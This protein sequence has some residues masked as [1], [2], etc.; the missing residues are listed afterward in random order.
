MHDDRCGVGPDY[1]VPDALWAQRVRV[2]PPPTPKQQEGRPRRDDR[3]A[4]TAIL[5]VLRTGC[6]WKALPRRRGAPSTVPDRFQAWRAAKGVSGSGRQ[7]CG[8]MMS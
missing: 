5:D 7:G 1:Q 3:P 6:H 4:M 2:L 8:R